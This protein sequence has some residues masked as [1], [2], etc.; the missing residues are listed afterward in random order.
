MPGDDGPPLGLSWHVEGERRVEMDEYE[1]QRLSSRRPKE[2]YCSV[3]CVEPQVRAQ[4]LLHSGSTHRQIN[5]IKKEVAKLNRERW[6]VRTKAYPIRGRSPRLTLGLAHDRRPRKSSSTTRGSSRRIASPSAT[7]SS[8]WSASPNRTA[9]RSMT[10]AGAIL[11]TSRRPSRKSCRC[12]L[13]EAPSARRGPCGRHRRPGSGT[14][15]ISMPW[16]RAACAAAS[17]VGACVTHAIPRASAAQRPCCLACSSTA[18]S[19]A[20]WL[21]STPLGRPV[22]PEV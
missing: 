16:C 7:T 12:A 13:A 22:E 11:S 15:R 2:T 8:R 19:S 3:G 21:R 10:R 1:T 20:L 9:S 5:S 18:V 17:R 14:P 6:Q 4:I